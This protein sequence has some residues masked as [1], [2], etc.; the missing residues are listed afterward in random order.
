[1]LN[2]SIYGFNQKNTKEIKYILEELELAKIT[3][4]FQENKDFE[5]FNYKVNPLDDVL[6]VFIEPVSIE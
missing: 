2:C 5:E 6:I 1:M 3:K 4:T